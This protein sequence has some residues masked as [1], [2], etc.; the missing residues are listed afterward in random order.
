[1]NEKV[2]AGGIW[3]VADANANTELALDMSMC[4][5]CLVDT[6]SN[7]GDADYSMDFVH[8]IKD[9]RSHMDGV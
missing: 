7:W 2:K 9:S 6:S 4:G 8:Q 1:M 5:G 3:D